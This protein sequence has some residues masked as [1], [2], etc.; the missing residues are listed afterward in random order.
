MEFFIRNSLDMTL[1][2]CYSIIRLGGLLGIRDDS[3]SLKKKRRIDVHAIGR[4]CVWISMLFCVYALLVSSI[5]P[6]NS[7]KTSLE[8]NWVDSNGEVTSL[9]IFRDC[10]NPTSVFY[11][12]DEITENKS[13][14]FRSRNI[15]IDVYVNGRLV[16]S[17]D[18]NVFP[19]FGSSYGSKWNNIFLEKSQEPVTIEIKGWAC[20]SNSKGIV[21]N[22]YIAPSD[23]IFTVVA[24]DHLFAF[25]LNAFWEL[26]GI[27]LLLLY[28]FL[29]KYY[30]LGKD[31]LYLSL[32]TLLCAQWCNAEINMWQFFLGNSEF[33]HFIGYLS[34]IT[35]PFGLL[36]INRLKGKWKKIAQ[37]YTVFAEIAFIVTFALNVTGILEFHYTVKVEHVLLY[38][39]VPLSVKVVQGY[40]QGDHIKKY[41]KLINLI[42]ILLLCFIV[43]GLAR[44]SLGYLADYDTYLRTSLFLFLLLMI[45]CQFLGINSVFVKGME[46]EFL[47]DMAIRDFLTKFYNR[48]GY[49]E[50]ETEY[51]E[52]RIKNKP[53][54]V[55]Q[56]DINDLKKVNDIQGH[57]KGDELICLA[58]SG[59][60]QSFGKT[61]RCYRMGGDEFLV[62]LPGEDPTGDYEAG[63]DKLEE[64]C[65]YA[66]N[67]EDRTFD[68]K[69]AHGFALLESEEDIAYALARAD[70]N[71][72]E[73]KRNMKGPGATIR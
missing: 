64:Y 29:H 27:I 13:I 70:E 12:F 41:K 10:E 42:L 3:F 43:A 47:H 1:V 44:Y 2:L 63:I 49:A 65:K 20:F 60:Y 59:I 57:E 14:M 5:F 25:I 19:L 69:I 56:F 28:V 31:F 50:H 26:F 71:M 11:T 72:Y 52:R 48:A 7:K 51:E 8:G 4:V 6:L 30:K 38:C 53:L 45:V 66:N 16:Q 24:K 21:T 73:N 39:M 23:E 46:A 54:G 55:I 33:F 22:F 68:L 18:K 62:I 15:F 36:G 32:G 37:V 17:D 67:V 35:I 58:S 9:D 40:T 61:G 34:L